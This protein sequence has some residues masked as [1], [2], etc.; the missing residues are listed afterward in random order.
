MSSSPQTLETSGAKYALIVGIDRFRD[1]NIP[2]LRYAKNDAAAVRDFLIHP[3]LGKF[4]RE[5]VHVLLDEEATLGDI[6]SQFV[7]WLGAKVQEEDHVWVYFAGYGATLP[8]PG[9]AEM[10]YLVAHDTSAEELA[11]S[12]ISLEQLGEWLGLISARRVVLIFD[13]G[14][15]G[16]GRGRTLAIS[17]SRVA[18]EYP[19][20]ATLTQDRR[21][22]A[23]LAASANENACEDDEAELGLFTRILLQR[24]RATLL[25]NYGP[26]LTWAALQ[27][28]LTA[29]VSRQADLR[30]GA[31]TP[32]ALGGLPGNLTIFGEA[33]RPRTSITELAQAAPA[34]QVQFL[35]REAQQEI[36]A[37]NLTHARELLLEILALDATNR[38]ARNGLRKLEEVLLKGDRETQIKHAFAEAQ[39]FW[40]ERNYEEA[41]RW[42]GK[43]LELDPTSE[44][45]R[46]GVE[47]S[48]A[49]LHRQEEHTPNGLTPGMR[50]TAEK[51]IHAPKLNPYGEFIWPYIG[52][53]ALVGAVWGLFG[54]PNEGASNAAIFVTVMEYGIIGG[55]IGLVH[56]SAVYFYK[57]TH[58]RMKVKKA[59]RA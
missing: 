39:R 12:G 9:R 23:L 41:T 27:Q 51:T 35:L 17:K 54:A 11:Q 49:M 53:W 22:I 5:N 8:Q 15:S 13:C 24:L 32:L 52:W 3:D 30:G 47:T 31:Q 21:R 10:N 48:Q 37:D 40:D 2:A 57:L 50:A 25:A 43:V 34:E 33:Q 59:R 19:C 28:Y 38:R 1:S 44:S 42:Y 14:F 18:P 26:E 20:F 6:R 29:E 56:A 46:V 4:S 16:A 45:A 58:V 7:Y 55:L 36:Y